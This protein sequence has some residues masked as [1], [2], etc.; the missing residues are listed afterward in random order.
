MSAVLSESGIDLALLS[1]A[2][3]APAAAAKLLEAYGDV[4]RLERAGAAAVAKAG[5]ITR[6]KAGRLLAALALGRRASLGAWP[7]GAP[8]T[9]SA[10][11]ARAFSPLLAPL[12]HEEF[13]A[14]PLT[15]KHARLGSYVVA[16]GAVA[17]CSVSVRESFAEALK[18]GAAGI[19]FLHNH[20]SGD[21]APSQDDHALTSVLVRAGKLLDIPVV[22]HIVLARGGYWSYAD[23]RKL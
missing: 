19:V 22:D 7:L 1:D 4:A 16:R 20:P 23:N 14:V 5:G 8:F 17:E 18:M 15:V 2:L 11:V 13:W 12:D 3:G 10:D 21:P 6:E 9:C